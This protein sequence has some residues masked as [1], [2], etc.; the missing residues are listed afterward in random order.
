MRGKKVVR[1]TVMVYRNCRETDE[2]FY[3]HFDIKVIQGDAQDPK[4]TRVRQ[5][6][7]VPHL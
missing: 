2:N 5:Q 4:E 7:L 1:T 6:S 3:T